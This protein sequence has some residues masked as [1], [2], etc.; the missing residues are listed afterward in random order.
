MILQGWVNTYSSI[1]YAGALECEQYVKKET[2]ESYVLFPIFSL[3]FS[4]QNLPFGLVSSNS[5]IWW[6]AAVI[7]YSCTTVGSCLLFLPAWSHTAL[8]VSF[9]VLFCFFL[10]RVVLD[11]IQTD[12]TQQRTGG[13]LQWLRLLGLWPLRAAFPIIRRNNDLCDTSWMRHDVGSSMF[14]IL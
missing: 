3:F 10:L 12:I 14:P 2:M 11:V 7:I 13:S 6:L 5:T 1:L 4:P 9:F 8:C